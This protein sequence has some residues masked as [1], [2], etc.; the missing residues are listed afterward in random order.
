MNKGQRIVENLLHQ[1]T[2]RRYY[3]ELILSGIKVILNEGLGSFRLK[4]KQWLELWMAE[5]KKP[6]TPPGAPPTISGDWHDYWIL[7]RKISDA[8]RE[9]LESSAPKVPQMI[10]IG[11][12]ELLSYAKSVQFPGAEK[13]RV[14][15]VIPVYNNE[16]LTIECLI[17]ILR[18]TKEV[19]YEIIIVDDSSTERTREVLSQIGNIKYLRNPENIGFLLS[20]NRAAEH[21]RGMFLLI[22]NNDVQVS[23]GWLSPLVETFS[24]YE[25]VGA[26]GPKVLYPDGRL[27][28]A[29]ARIK[30]DAS[31][32]LIGLLD[33]PELPRYNYVREVEYCSGVCL[34]LETEMF[35]K[36]GGFDPSFAP[37]YY[38]D[39]DLCLRIRKL[40]KRIYYNSDS[41]IVHY[42]SATTI[43]V[44]EAYKQECITRNRQKLSE[45]WQEQ[46]DGLNRVRLIAF[47]LPQYHPVPENDRWWG[48]GFTDWVNV[49]K[50]R[51]NF[52]GHYQPHL[53]GDL[54]FYDLRVEEV[55]EQQAELAKRYGIY[56]LCFLYYWFGGKRLLEFPLERMLKSD[57]PNIPFCLC[58]ANENWTRRC[59]GHEDQVLIAQQHS[60]KDDVAV[61]RDIMRH[62]RHPNYIRINGKPL[63]LVYHAGLFGDIRR[64]T[65]TWRDLCQEEGIGEIYLAMVESFEHPTQ[66]THPSR[67]GFDAS[68]ECPPHHLWA[69]IKPPGKK[70]NQNYSGVVSDYREAVLRYLQKEIPGFTRFRTVVPGWDNTPRLQ[71]YSHIFAHTSP[72][73]YQAWLEAI[74]E[75]TME[76]NFGE[77]RVVFINAWNEWADGSYLEPDRLFG[78]G[79]LEATRNALERHLLKR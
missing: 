9:R 40:G 62:M 61:I 70:L 48:T 35:R 60:D 50:A 56:G 44:N 69:P 24:K 74:V 26:V 1:G 23:Q 4:F 10:S 57:K 6:E 59:D 27:Q 76:Q 22:L 12:E 78:H 64:T 79:F 29:G 63:L 53:P 18:N 17:S 75:L 43:K 31:A 72:G 25:N 77:E 71:D 32:Q 36:L 15:I 21:A 11:E 45:R 16:R 20:C 67:Y 41:V 37:A 7:S 66:D 73:A 2:R 3:Y 28:E 65:M 55:M 46:I 30:Q 8:K 34:L 38:E 42:L 33:D 52:V 58:W 5:R 51:P 19:S 13:P 49:V 39:S 14:S 68:V 54:G 47:Y